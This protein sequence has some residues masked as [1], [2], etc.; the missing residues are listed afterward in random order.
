MLHNVLHVECDTQF[1]NIV[2]GVGIEPNAIIRRWMY[3]LFVFSNVWVCVY[4]SQGT[5]TI[6]A[7]IGVFLSVFACHWLCSPIFDFE[8]VFGTFVSRWL[9]TSILP[10]VNRCTLG[11][12]CTLGCTRLPL[13]SPRI[14]KDLDERSQRT[15]R[16]LHEDLLRTFSGLAKCRR[17]P[18]RG[19][20][21]HTLI[22]IS[23]C[24]FS[25]SDGVDCFSSS[26]TPTNQD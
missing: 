13:D 12:S 16:G 15:C 10:C 24:S 4:V 22:T 20:P 2:A 25:T 23:L 7:F 18:C 8:A 14:W 5:P 11:F 6:I 17:K 19:L 1:G 21:S 3:S 26:V 9:H